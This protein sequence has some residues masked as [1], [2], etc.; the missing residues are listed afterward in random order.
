[1][2]FSS[3]GY[4]FWACLRPIEIFTEIRS[5]SSSIT[6]VE[7]ELRRVSMSP[8]PLQEAERAFHSSVR[9]FQLLVGRRGEHHE[10]ARGIGTVLVDDG[11]RIHTVVFGLGHLLGAADDHRLAV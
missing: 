7:V 11:L 4:L 8:H 2:N 3:Q 1:M 5:G 6:W 10:Q 9:P